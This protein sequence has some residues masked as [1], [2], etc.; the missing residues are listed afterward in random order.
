M[1]GSLLDVAHATILAWKSSGYPL[2]CCLSFNFSFSPDP[3][4]RFFLDFLHLCSFTDWV[5][6]VFLAPSLKTTSRFLLGKYS[7][8]KTV[9]KL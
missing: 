3:A 7:G 2:A 4:F 8:S 5:R 1:S 6:P 9:C